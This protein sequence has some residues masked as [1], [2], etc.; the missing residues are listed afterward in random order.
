[1]KGH[2]HALALDYAD[3]RNSIDASQEEDEANGETDV[4]GCR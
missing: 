2:A 1:M 3:H 4:D